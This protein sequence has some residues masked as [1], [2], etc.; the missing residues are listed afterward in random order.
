MGRDGGGCGGNGQAATQPLLLSRKQFPRSSVMSTLTTAS[1]ASTATATSSTATLV[2]N[3][4]DFNDIAAV[5]E[6]KSLKVCFSNFFKIYLL[7]IFYG[8]IQYACYI[9]KFLIISKYS[10]APS[11]F[12][13]IFSFF[14]AWRKRAIVPVNCFQALRALFAQ[15]MKS[16]SMGND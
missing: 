12:C 2:N 11:F 15:T 7:T 3:N 14:L 16:K 9:F 8:F 1:S 13:L 5:D 6:R 10:Y 4:N